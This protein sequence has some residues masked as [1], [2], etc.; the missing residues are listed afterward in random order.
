MKVRTQHNEM[1]FRQTL[2]MALL[3][4]GLS[5]SGSVGAQAD[6]VDES[7]DLGQISFISGGIGADEAEAMKAQ[8]SS[9]ALALTFAQHQRGQDVY[10]ASVPVVIRTADGGAT[11]LDTVTE[12][13]YLL[14]NLP[15]GRYRVSAVYQHNEK[16]AEVQ[17]RAGAHQRHTF[18]WQGAASDAVAK[19]PATSL[20]TATEPV[21][22][23]PGSVLA[24]AE[25]AQ[26]IETAAPDSGSRKKLPDMPCTAGGLPVTMDDVDVALKRSFAEVFGD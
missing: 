16:T 3:S 8:A 23:S 26:V 2:G 9:Y 6:P 7:L 22:S 11:V 18:V 10:L 17:V 19:V 24:T 21:V 1:T 5:L 13:P 12:G 20:P 14:V 4:I 25:P 15:E